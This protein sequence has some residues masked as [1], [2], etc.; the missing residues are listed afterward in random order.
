MTMEELKQMTS[1]ENLLPLKK[2]KYLII[3]P[4]TIQ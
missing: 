3:L 4:T 1:P 2:A